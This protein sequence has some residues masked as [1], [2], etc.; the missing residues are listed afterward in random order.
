MAVW[1]AKSMLRP[2]LP[3]PSMAQAELNCSEP[4]WTPTE[5]SMRPAD[6][7]LERLQRH[8]ENIRRIARELNVDFSSRT[9][10]AGVKPMRESSGSLRTSGASAASAAAGRRSAGASAGA[11]AKPRGDPDAPDVATPA[12]PRPV[13]E[14]QSSKE[15]ESVDEEKD[16][17]GLCPE[18]PSTSECRR[19]TWRVTSSVGLE[20][21]DRRTEPCHVT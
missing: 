10:P 11:A 4:N 13:P 9:D 1:V 16:D 19:L 6:G 7:R 12:A 5:T 2:F 21:T 18:P 20:M 3:G 8:R 17:I 15:P 14:P